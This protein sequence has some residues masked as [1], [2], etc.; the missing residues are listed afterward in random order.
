MY[1]MYSRDLL[2][3]IYNRILKK[4]QEENYS[5]DGAANGGR[6]R[7]KNDYFL[8]PH[9]KVPGSNPEKV[10]QL[11]LFILIEYYKHYNKSDFDAPEIHDVALKV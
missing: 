2:A 7:A 3:P 11:V 5:I 10:K 6:S 4:H 9:E 8:V 1:N